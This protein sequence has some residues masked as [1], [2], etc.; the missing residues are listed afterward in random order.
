MV[1]LLPYNRTKEN[2]QHLLGA[3]H[4]PQDRNTGQSRTGY[5]QRF[6]RKELTLTPGVRSGAREMASEP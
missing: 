6:H 3:P 1:K 4:E 5:R 2:C